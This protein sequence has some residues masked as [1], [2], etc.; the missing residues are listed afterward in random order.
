MTVTL[1]YSTILTVTKWTPKKIRKLR[2]DLD[3]TQ[4]EF[5]KRLGV[6]RVYLAY[7]EQEGGKYKPSATMSLLLD[8]I[9]KER[10]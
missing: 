4:A 9:S 10:R 3:M 8:C 1:H 2:Q 5:G 6:S 7:L